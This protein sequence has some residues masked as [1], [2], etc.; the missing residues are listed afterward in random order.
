MTALLSFLIILSG[1]SSFIEG[2]VD[3]QGDNPKSVTVN[4]VKLDGSLSDSKSLTIGDDNTFK[5]DGFGEGKYLIEV[6]A[7]GHQVS[8]YKWISNSNTEIVI[9]IGKKIASSSNSEEINETIKKD[10]GS[11]QSLIS[12]PQY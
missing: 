4:I 11:G 5:S 12:P 10:R 8:S 7:P 6:V 3:I 1:C 2:R 9:P